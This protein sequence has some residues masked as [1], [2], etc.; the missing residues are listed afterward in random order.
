MTLVDQ[1]LDQRQHLG[2]VRRGARVDRRALDVVQ[3][4]EAQIG[5]DVA[6]AHALVGNAL[7]VGALDDLVVD[8]GEVVEV[9]DLVAQVLQVTPHDLARQRGADVPHVGLVL[10]RH[11]AHVHADLA[12]YHRHECQPELFHSKREPQGTPKQRRQVGVGLRS[13]GDGDPVMVE[14]VRVFP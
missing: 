13:F 1:S 6:L 9:R 10:D 8:V 12:G 5:V 11:P 4:G 2:D 7:G 3:V 14:Q